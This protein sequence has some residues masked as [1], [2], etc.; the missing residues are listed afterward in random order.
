MQRRRFLQ[1]LLTTLG[2]AAIPGKALASSP[3]LAWIPLQTSPLAGFQ[4]HAGEIVW[5]ALA[6]GDWLILAREPQNPYD[7]RAVRVE[8][9]GFMLGYVPRTENRAVARL[10]DNGALLGARVKTLR[11]S[12]N[13]WERVQL[14]I[15]VRAE[16]V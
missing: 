9:R 14:E 16:K 2:L 5:P 6:Q 4:H 15:L 11:E 12:S 7:P 1:S 13:P 10:L 3:A 8:W